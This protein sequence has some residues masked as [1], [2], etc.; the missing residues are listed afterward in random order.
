MTVCTIR[1]ESMWKPRQN[2]QRTNESTVLEFWDYDQEKKTVTKHHPK[3]ITLLLLLWGKGS[4]NKKQQYVSL[5][6]S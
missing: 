2:V 6:N 5:Q 1:Q 4:F 3:T